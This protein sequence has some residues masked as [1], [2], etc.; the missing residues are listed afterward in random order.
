MWSPCK[1]SRRACS[2]APIRRRAPLDGHSSRILAGL[3][4]SW[5]E[6][7]NEIVTSTYLGWRGLDLDENF[8]GF[9]ESELGDGRR[10]M[11]RAVTGGGRV[12]WRHR[13]SPTTRVLSGVEVIHDRMQQSEDRITTAGAVY[14]NERELEAATTSG[15]L[16]A[17]LEATRGAWTAVG[18]ARVDALMIDSIDRL[19]RTRSG[20]GNVA[21]VSPKLAVTW[22]SGELLGSAAA[23]RGVRPPEARA[24]TI[25]PSRENMEAATYDGGDPEITKADGVELGGQLRRARLA[26]GVTGFATTIDRESIFDH[27]SGANILLDGSRRYGVEAFVEAKP[28]SYLALRGDVTAVDA[29]FT[30][31]KNPVPGHRA[32][33]AA[34]RLASIAR[35]GTRG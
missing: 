8:T 12:A 25:R 26:L 17:G 31:S 18:G 11:H 27:V 13:L 6:R 35:R 2:A 30:V 22:R 34:S 15:G 33:S 29:R 9:L 3:S 21:A 1:T 4:S 20:R 14:R 19:D 24:F 28:L 5:K 10:Q 16:W 7:A 32:S 23:G